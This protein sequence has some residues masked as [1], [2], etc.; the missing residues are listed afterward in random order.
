MDVTSHKRRSPTHPT[1]C[2]GYNKCYTTR[3]RSAALGRPE[4]SLRDAACHLQYRITRCRHIWA[5]EGD[6]QCSTMTCSPQTAELGCSSRLRMSMMN[7]ARMGRC[8]ASGW[9]C[10][11]LLPF[12]KGVRCDDLRNLRKGGRRLRCCARLVGV[13]RSRARTI[14][15]GALGCCRTKFELF[16]ATIRVTSQSTAFLHLVGGT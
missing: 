10:V 15:G 13:T 3:R 6:G 5:Y 12:K 7:R 8:G 11:I 9:F 14:V 2:T 4:N 1:R 16:F